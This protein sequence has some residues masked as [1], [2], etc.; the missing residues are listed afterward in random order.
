MK[1]ENSTALAVVAGSF[2]SVFF[3]LGGLAVGILAGW[4]LH[5]KKRQLPFF[6]N[7]DSQSDHEYAGLI[8]NFPSDSK[9]E[10]ANLLEVEEGEGEEDNE[11]GLLDSKQS[12]DNVL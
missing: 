9:S 2:L 6:R 10:N 7:W 4:K 3:L 12:G 11:E 8:S 1:A 5:E